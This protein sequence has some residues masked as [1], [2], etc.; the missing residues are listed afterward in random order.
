MQRR[1]DAVS[2]ELLSGFFGPC[3]CLPAK[4]P[5]LSPLCLQEAV[6]AARRRCGRGLLR[7]EFVSPA[8]RGSALRPEI[9]ELPRLGCTYW[10]SSQGAARVPNAEIKSGKR[11]D[12]ETRVTALGRSHQ[13]QKFPF[14]VPTLICISLYAALHYPLQ[15]IWHIPA[16]PRCSLVALAVTAATA[17][18]LRAAFFF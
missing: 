15:H 18:A 9:Q 4:R 7:A 17:P 8:P 6:A 2:F 10:K 12:L 13:R 14:S 5:A 11:G 16:L 3:R 1:A